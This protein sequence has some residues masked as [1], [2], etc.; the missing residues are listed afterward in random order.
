MARPLLLVK[1]ACYA[2]A[3][4]LFAGCAGPSTSTSATLPGAALTTQAPWSTEAP[5]AA[6]SQTLFVLRDTSRQMVGRIQQLPRFEQ[7]EAL[8]VWLMLDLQRRGVTQLEAPLA[9]ESIF[10]ANL[11]DALWTIEDPNSPEFRREY[12]VHHDP[13]GVSLLFE[14]TG[15][16]QALATSRDERIALYK[17]L[18]L[19]APPT[20]E[21]PSQTAPCA[22]T[23]EE[24]G[25]ISVNCPGQL[26]TIQRRDLTLPY[27]TTREDLLTQ[28]KAITA[29]SNATDIAEVQIVGDLNDERGLVL[30]LVQREASPLVEITHLHRWHIKGT[31]VT[32]LAASTPTLLLPKEDARATLDRCD[33]LTGASD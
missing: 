32:M 2:V 15:P 7:R 12:L 24:P 16:E 33:A 18:E 9:A 11:Q 3:C 25:L 13:A 21:L 22:Q 31:S 6:S 27:P 10:D 1:F 5:D 4:L 20:T 29:T 19:P 8:L 23:S 26:L 17:T 14:M 30:E 28:F